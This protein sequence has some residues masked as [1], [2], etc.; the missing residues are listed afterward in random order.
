MLD[1]INAQTL[2]NMYGKSKPNLGERGLEIPRQKSSRNDV[3]FLSSPNSTCRSFSREHMGD[4]IS[5][6]SNRL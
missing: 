5:G 6:S 2:P 3:L 4:R 1:E